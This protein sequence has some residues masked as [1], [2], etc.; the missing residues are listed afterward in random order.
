STE[1]ISLSTA[2]ASIS[3]S[4]V[5]PGLPNRISTHSCLRVSRN[6][7]FPE[8]TGKI[9]SDFSAVRAA[10]FAQQVFVFAGEYELARLIVDGRRH[11]HNAGR[12]LRGQRR[13]DEDRIERV[14]DMDAFEKLRRL[15]DEADQT[16]ADQVRKRSR[17]R[18][19]ETEYLKAMRQHP[20]QAARLAIFDV[21]VDRVIIRGEHL[22]SG[23]MRL[24]HGAARA[25]K[26]LA[27][28]QIAKTAPLGDIECLR[29][30][31]HAAP[32]PALC[33]L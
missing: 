27:D 24:R 29:I 9:S 12:A 10:L 11:H 31:L 8:M 17:A 33:L 22:E 4:S 32:R 14:A 23:E 28:L 7:R 30:E 20:A 5:V 1:R 16:I 3:G 21:V 25:A 26:N 19:R 15:F 13:D 18:G 2:S 6:A